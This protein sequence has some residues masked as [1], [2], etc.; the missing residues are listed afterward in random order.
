ML[1]AG[2]QARFGLDPRLKHSG[3]TVLEVA[4][5]HS[6]AIFKGAHEGHEGS[7]NDIFEFVNFVA[8][9]VQHLLKFWLRLRRARFLAVV[10]GGANVILG[11]ARATWH[12][13][14]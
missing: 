1:L 7:E 10:I 4:S 8:F 2:I 3:V 13:P 9:V 5:L 6:A 12:P 11:A 14:A